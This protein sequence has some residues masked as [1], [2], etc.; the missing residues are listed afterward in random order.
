[1]VPWQTA[2]V[3]QEALINAP[4]DPTT[5]ALRGHLSTKRA[6]AIAE[7]KISEATEELDERLYLP[8]LPQAASA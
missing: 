5:S 6:L 7:A 2:G 1:M 8:H 4:I 3:Q